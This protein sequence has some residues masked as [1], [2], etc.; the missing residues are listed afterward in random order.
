MKIIVLDERLEI[1]TCLV[2]R[3]AGAGHEVRAAH[4]AEDAIDQGHLFRPDLLI[5]S[6]E[7]SGEYGG[8]EVCEA[9]F[10]ANAKA[11][12]ILISTQTTADPEE[13]IE[14]RLLCVTCE[15]SC[16]TE[17]MLERVEQ[18]LESCRGPMI[19]KFSAK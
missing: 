13:P 19:A 14:A 9:V 6:D 8:R 18:A 11:K 2:E 12:A 16:P 15:D 10:H 17:L 5:C 3:L 7:L 4:T 1:S